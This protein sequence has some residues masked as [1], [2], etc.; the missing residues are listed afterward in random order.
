MLSCSACTPCEPH[1]TSCGTS[2]LPLPLLSGFPATTTMALYTPHRLQFSLRELS[3]A[4][5]TAPAQSLSKPTRSEAGIPAAYGVG[6]CRTAALQETLPADHALRGAA[7]AAPH[8][9]P[10]TKKQLEYMSN[11]ALRKADAED[12]KASGDA[13]VSPRSQRAPSARSSSARGRRRQGM[14]TYFSDTENTRFELFLRR[15]ATRL[16]TGEGALE[17]EFFSDGFTSLPLHKT[18]RRTGSTVLGQALHHKLSNIIQRALAHRTVAVTVD[19]PLPEAPCP[20][21]GMPDVRTPLLHALILPM[22]GLALQ[23]LAAGASP[24][25]RHHATGD[26]AL[27][28]AVARCIQAPAPTGKRSKRKGRSRRKASSKPASDAEAADGPVQNDAIAIAAADAVHP[29][30]AAILNHPALASSS[31][32]GAYLARTNAKGSTALHIALSRACVWGG[33][34]QTQAVSAANAIALIRAGAD[35]R[36]AAPTAEGHEEE[37]AP[38]PSMLDAAVAFGLFSVVWWALRM[39]A[40]GAGAVPHGHALEEDDTPLDFTL[41]STVFEPWATAVPDEHASAAGLTLDG[42][43]ELR[44]AALAAL[45]DA[46]KEA[47]AAA[48]AAAAIPPPGMA[49]ISLNGYGRQLVYTDGRDASPRRPRVA[50]PRRSAR[51]GMASTAPARSARSQSA[52]GMAGDSQAELARTFAPRTPHKMSDSAASVPARP[53]TAEAASPSRSLLRPRQPS[54][55]KRRPTYHARSPGGRPLKPQVLVLPSNGLKGIKPRAR[56]GRKLRPVGSSASVGKEGEPE[57]A[58]PQAAG[59]VV[60]GAWDMGKTEEPVSSSDSEEEGPREVVSTFMPTG[61]IIQPQWDSPRDAPPPAPPASSEQQHA[62]DEASDEPEPLARQDAPADAPQ[63]PEPSSASDAKVSEG[64]QAPAKP[65]AAIPMPTSEEHAAATRIQALLRGKA[66]RRETAARR[67]AA[68][69]AEP[70]PASAK[71]AP[72]EPAP[73]S[74]I[75]AS[76]EPAP[77][78]A[79]P[80]SAEEA[81]A[82]KLQAVTRGH[83]ARKATSQSTP[84]VIPSTAVSGG[85]R[86]D[87]ASDTSSELDPFAD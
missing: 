41:R 61:P 5:K 7:E 33:D 11:P 62:R 64:N 45:E 30:V 39:G 50:S 81:A 71:P 60:P 20:V 55:G 43:M 40:L 79:R 10:L 16:G 83:L 63:S 86:P 67:E 77:A 80:A 19:T 56:K 6:V 22:P 66:A 58:Q 37:G 75:P 51:R 34:P 13:H 76:A 54:P 3:Q 26:T 46:E 4:V 48:A 85:A 65:A 38:T 18:H 68:S 73:A 57:A 28:L 31:K 53:S 32:A 59:P 44:A 21:L 8:H 35:V 27:M 82:T 84:V 29:V 14:A 69:L 47:K 15:L 49:W 52:A 72:T 74:A 24:L 87:G 25:Q 78:S 36:A 70:A 1:E 23:L 2:K 9:P 42:A 12:G 17:A